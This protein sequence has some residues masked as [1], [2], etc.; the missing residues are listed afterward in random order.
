MPFSQ[1]YIVLPCYCI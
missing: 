1:D